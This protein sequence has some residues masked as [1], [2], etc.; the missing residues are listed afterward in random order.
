[1]FLFKEGGKKKLC[2]KEPVN[3]AE[4]PNLGG[5]GIGQV[6]FCARECDLKFCI[7]NS[8]LTYCCLKERG[9]IPKYQPLNRQ[10]K[11]GLVISKVAKKMKETQKQNKTKMKHTKKR[12]NKMG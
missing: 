1:M 6:L 12:E 9:A 2:N 10:K 3:W 11:L 4:H 8:V 7:L 5:G